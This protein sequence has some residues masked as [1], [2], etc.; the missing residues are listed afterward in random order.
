MTKTE[1][2]AQKYDFAMMDHGEAREKAI[3]AELDKAI[4]QQDAHSALELYYVFMDENFFHGDDY[5]S[6]ILFPEYTAYFNKHPELHE[7]FQHDLMWSYKWIIGGIGNFPQLPLKQIENLFN[8]YIDFCK[9]FNYNLRSYY[10]KLINFMIHHIRTGDTFCGM[11]VQEAYKKFLLTKRDDMSDCQA[12][13]TD[14]EMTYYIEVEHD[15]EKA[16]KKAKPILT[17]VLSCSEIPHVT[18]EELAHGYFRGK[19]IIN[20]EKYARK[21]V[22]LMLRDYGEEAGLLQSKS[23]CFGILAF[24]DPRKALTVMKKCL[25]YTV[26]NK[27][28]SDMFYFNQAAYYLCSQLKEHEVEKIRIRLPYRNEDIYQEDNIYSTSD[29]SEYFYDKAMELAEKFDQRNGNSIYTDMLKMNMEFDFS[30]YKPFEDELDIPILDYIRENIDEGELPLDFSLPRPKKEE[31]E[32]SFADG[33]M[34]GIMLY[35]QELKP[36]ELGELEEIFQEAA[37]GNKQAYRKTVHY[38]E[39]N[40]VRTLALIDTVQNYIIDHKEELNPEEMFSY[41]VDLMVGTKNTEAVKLGLAILELFGSFNDALK[42]AMLDI[43]LCDEFTVFVLWA[44]RNLE[45]GNDLV[46]SIAQK[47]HGWG[48]I[49]AVAMLEPETEEIRQWLLEDGC[50]NEV[51]PGYSA[52]HCFVKADVRTLLKNGLKQEQLNAVGRIILFLILDGPTNGIHA[53]EDAEEIVSL[54]LNNAERL[55]KNEID[56]RI[57]KAIAQ[58]YDDEKAV[59]RI[60]DMEIDISEDEE[61]T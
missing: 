27:N 24:T 6:T 16:L 5:N 9:R 12:C 37:K 43:A 61:E 59:Q 4:E 15:M 49:H 48:R 50:N 1:M 35:H 42:Q 51:Y 20:A 31:E 14:F 10:H 57:L 45:D 13:E 55:E 2:Y 23:I 53:F 7:E 22:R 47:A 30:D 40:D 8:Q 3:K 56:D 54:Y 28:G 26:N 34:D 25:P 18:Y 60:I 19:D 36:A 39:N 58:N 21:S 29:L 33:A 44:V 41:A 32:T 52:I 38:F 17:G 46:F 11:T